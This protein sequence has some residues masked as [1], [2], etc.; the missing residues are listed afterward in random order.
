MELNDNCT[1]DELMDHA[2]REI[3][4][5]NYCARGYVICIACLHGVAK[6]LGPKLAKRKLAI[7]QKR[8]KKLKE[9]P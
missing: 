4:C 8:L 9:T 3:G 2:C 5:C 6:K 7:D 1:N